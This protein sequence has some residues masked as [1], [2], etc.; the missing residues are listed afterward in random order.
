MD[1]AVG[2]SLLV[3][4]SLVHATTVGT[5]PGE[6]VV[7]QGVAQYQIPINLPQGRGGNTPKLSISY[8]SQG[9]TNTI[10]G[11][12]F[13]LSGLSSISRCGS[14]ISTDGEVRAID[15]SEHDNFCFDGARLVTVEG[16]K[17]QD[18]SVYRLEMD[19]YSKVTLHGNAQD[20]SSYFTVQTKD[21]DHLTFANQFHNQSWNLTQAT[22]TTGKNPINYSYD[23]HGKITSI[24]YDIFTVG[25]VYSPYNGVS[26]NQKTSHYKLNNTVYSSDTLL[27]KITINTAGQLSNYYSIERRE[28]QLRDSVSLTGQKVTGIEYCDAQNTCLPKTS[29]EWEATPEF[30]SQHTFLDQ[31][32]AKKTIGDWGLLNKPSEWKSVPRSWWADIDGNRQLDFCKV[33]STGITCHFNLPQDE[34]VEK[35]FPIS[36]W[37]ESKSHWWQDINSDGKSEF[38]RKNDNDLLCSNFHAD[39]SETNFSIP[40]THWGMEDYRWWLDIN[41]D[42]RADFCRREVDD[43]RCSLNK[44]GASWSNELLITDLYWSDAKSTQWTDIDGNGSQDLCRI[45]AG[46][47]RCTRFNN[48]EVIGDKNQAHALSDLGDKARR[49]WVDINGDGASDFCRATG[50]SSGAGSNLTCS[51][52][53]TGHFAELTDDLILVGGK[54]WFGN[55]G[56][57]DKR[58]WQDFNKDGKVDFCRGIGNVMHCTNMFGE[59]HQFKVDNWGSDYRW[60]FDFDN[61]GQTDFCRRQ[62]GDLV[63]D[64]NTQVRSPQHLLSKVT[65]GLGHTSSVKFGPYGKHSSVSALDKPIFP[66]IATSESMLVAYRLDT[67]NGAGQSSF[68]FQYGPTTYDLHRKNTS[69]FAWIKQRE[70]VNGNNT[71]NRETHYYTEFPLS[72]KMKSIQEF[73]SNDQLLSTNSSEYITDEFW[74]FR[75]L[76]LFNKVD[77]QYD[78]LSESFSSQAT[79]YSQTEVEDQVRD[80]ARAL[81]EV[82]YQGKSYFKKPDI[83]VPV[84]T[85]PHIPVI[86][87]SNEYYIISDKKTVSSGTEIDTVYAATLVP[88]PASELGALKKFARKSL[89]LQQVIDNTVYESIV[90]QAPVTVTNSIHSIVEKRQQDK[91]YDLEGNLLATVT[92]EHDNIDK[93]GNIGLIRVTTSGKNPITGQ[94]ESFVKVTESEHQNDQQRWFLGRLARSKVTHIHAS[95]E[96]KVK[97]STFEYDQNTGLLIK[98]ISDPGHRLAVET[99]YLRDAEGNVETTKVTA[100]HEKALRTRVN[101]EQIAYFGTNIRQTSTNVMGFSSEKTIDRLNGLTVM[102]GI[103][104]LE[105]RTYRDSFGRITEKWAQSENGFVKTSIGYYSANSSQCSHKPTNGAV[106]CT[107]TETPGFSQSVTFYDMFQRELR[108]ASLGQ[109]GRWIYKDTAYNARNQIVSVS[110]AYYKGDIPQYSLTH[111]DSIGRLSSVS[112]PGPAG[113][114]V[115]WG[116]YEYG[117]SWVKEVDA[118]GRLEV[119]YYN[120]MGWIIHVQQPEGA[121]VTNTYFPDGLLKSA[122]SAGNHTITNEYNQQGA[123]SSMDD[124]DMGLWHYQYDGFGQLISQTDAK[125]Q[126]TTMSYDNLGRMTSRV[127]EEITYVG[128]ESVKEYQSTNWFYDTYA[129][130][131]GIREWKGV[132]LRVEQSGNFIK[133]FYYTNLGQLEKEELITPEQTL[134]RTFDFN[135]LGQMISETRPNEFKVNYERDAVTGITT[136]IW[137]DTSQLQ[138][139]FSEEEY[140]KVIQPLLNE[141]LVKATD[142]VAKAKEL[143]TQQHVYTARK[144]E[145]YALRDEIISIDG[146]AEIDDFSE[147]ASAELKGRELSVYKSASG[148]EYF[149]VPDRVVIISGITDVPVIQR[150]QYHLKLENNRLRKVSFAEWD[151]VKSTLTNTNEIAFYGEFAGEQGLAKLALERDHPLYDQLLRKYFNR[152]NSLAKDI[153]RLEYVEDHT[154]QQATSY[155]EAAQQLVTLVKQVKLVSA[156]YQKLGEQSYSEYQSLSNLISNNGIAGRVYYW[157]LNNLDADG[158][159]VSELYGNGLIN[160]YDYNEGNGQLQNVATTQGLKTIR[161]LHYVY[162]RMDNVT[163][164]EDLVNH[165]SDSY[166]YD[167]LDRLKSNKVLGMDGKHQHNPLFNKTNTMH[168]DRAGNM[169]YKSDVGHYIYAD[170]NHPHA[171]TQAG[172]KNYNY[173]ING[174]MLSGDGRQIKWSSFNKPVNIKQ[175]ESWVGFSYDQNRLRY[176]KENSSGDK[177]W[178]LGKAYERVENSNG[179]VEHKQFISAGGKLIAINIDRQKSNIEG[180]TASFDRQ[181]R[182]VHGDAL[183]SVDLVTDNWANVVDRKSYDAWGKER[184]FEWEKDQS[185][186]EQMLMTNRGY[187]GHEHVDEVDMIHMGGR[188]YDPVL[189]RF[190]Q[191]DPYI[192]AVQNSQSF[193]RYS[194]VLNNPLNYTDPSGYSWKRVGKFFKK[195]WKIITAVTVTYATGGIA[196]GWAASW[197]LAAGSVGNAIA[198]GAIAGSVGGAVGGGLITESFRGALKGSLSGA[199]AGAAGGYANFGFTQGFTD[200]VKRVSVAALGGCASGEIS[201]GSC[202]QGAKFAAYA[203]VIALS[204]KYM[205]KV[206]DEYKLKSCGKNGSVCK[207]NDQGELLTDGGR[208]ELQMKGTSPGEG[209]WLTEGGMASEGSGLHYY[210]ENSLLGRFI[211][212]VSKTHD[213]FNSDISKIFGFQGYDSATGLWL[214]GTEAYNTMYQ[215]YSFGGMIPAAV[216]TGAAMVAPYQYPYSQLNKQLKGYN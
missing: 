48:G 54:D 39:G 10:V 71:N 194:Y 176:F 38:C 129:G 32:V 109:E 93:F 97:K 118:K 40:L 92:V 44:D 184:R 211:N 165:I 67:D 108:V 3:L 19:N 15:F 172:D 207:Y 99:D 179:E 197:G 70:F 83:Y 103:N 185:H 50:Q 17:G 76:T 55:W 177:T 29:F 204:V 78:A 143:Q 28:K 85:S 46:V 89:G 33:S 145:Y 73:Y 80:K 11:P 79:R 188:I 64:T 87:P 205:A 100:L 63:C 66:Y 81:E 51:L 105:S 57:A 192:Q 210:N 8:S 128:S 106:Y 59:T 155:L 213:Y 158:R 68:V 22:D 61:D 166:T 196:S 96:T 111:Y 41:G 90:T 20:N 195:N 123:K 167:D 107:V 6:L 2:L 60:W 182:Y 212:K 104:G 119:T 149:E 193:N 120:A 1:K 183:Q 181:I 113:K 162:D 117:P 148:E 174:N 102:K 114:G 147:Q 138:L 115:N 153:D 186:V 178:Y 171:V 110:R 154:R 94:V 187:T 101:K 14:T 180:V 140:K 24:G 23:D 31:F 72:Q 216:Y 135:H 134:V 30:S 35:T 88:V 206:T 152:L 12:G 150:A 126:T 139:N 34:S 58:W 130:S 160:A 56:A 82:T 121:T 45:G 9:S 47:V 201:G 21:G 202:G 159:V 91:N 132:L 170:P 175:G 42:G 203:Q 84:G 133:Q 62:G 95:G 200:A 69:G 142:Y 65:N 208:G 36:I 25:F 122:T 163:L 141:A 198:T 7:D 169:T 173:D 199:I 191:A 137:G 16:T 189:G 18:S 151:E 215:V 157:K 214:S 146:L 124:P 75:L 43:L 168:Y 52:G 98:E 116:S 127:D 112:K 209:N 156:R 190:L 136:K 53:S 49:W 164:R 37:G 161:K 125:G 26:N 13:S 131:T 5:L 144:D 77:K 4:S 74:D 86:I 27:S